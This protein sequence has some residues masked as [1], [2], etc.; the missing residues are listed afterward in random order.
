[1]LDPIEDAVNIPL[2]ELPDR[3]HELPP[4]SRLIT[5]VAKDELAAKTLEVL[6]A[7]GREARSTSEFEVGEAGGRLWEPSAFLAEVLPSLVSG[8]ALDLACGSGRDAVFMSSLGWHVTGVDILP[9]ALDK[10][11]DLATRYLD[12]PPHPI[13]VQ[14]DLES[15]LIDLGGP[16]DLIFSTSYLNRPLFRDLPRWLTPTGSVILETF[17]VVHR[18]RHGKPSSDD[19]V[20]NEGEILEFA[21]G[22]Q[23]RRF[24]EGWFDGRHTQRL[25]ASQKV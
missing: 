1:M 10:A 9:D 3:M 2:D 12:Q 4:R 24:E 22:L 21:V 7:S 11:R 8:K 15:G 19:H 13:F 6:E 14:T 25:W 18:E 17:T 20:L 23:V 16:Y 5:V